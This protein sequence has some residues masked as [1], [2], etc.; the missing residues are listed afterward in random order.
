MDWEKEE[1]ELQNQAVFWDRVLKNCL[2][3]MASNHDPPDLY[4]LS[5]QDYRRESLA[6]SHIWILDASVICSG[7]MALTHGPLAVRHLL[8]WPGPHLSLHP[9]Q[10]YL[11]LFLVGSSST[12]DPCSFRGV[13][14]DPGLLHCV[15]SS[16]PW[17]GGKGSRVFLWAWMPQSC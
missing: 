10:R 3:R 12:P 7:K 8:F 16:W 11:T 2:P 1:L 5:K 4:L 14:T 6:P 13:G 15:P 9:C 17:R